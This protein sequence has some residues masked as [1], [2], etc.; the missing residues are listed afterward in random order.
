MQNQNQQQNLQNST[1]MPPQQNEGG[2]SLFDT[3]EALGTVTGTLEHYL[4]YEQHI[5]DQ[6]LTT[7]LQ[8]H[9]TFISQLYNTLVETLK[10]GQDPSVPTQTYNMSLNNDVVYGMQPSAPKT[11]SQSVNEINDECVSSFMLGGLKSIATAFTT[12]ALEATNPVL[13]RVFSDSIPNVIEMAYEVFLYQNK[14]QYY[15]VPQLK[16]QDMQALLN[17]YAPIPGTMPH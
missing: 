14:H 1:Q 9:R 12:T 10:S 8:S 5:Q 4:L 7:I 16:E 17:S 3:H 13:R 6:E 15:Q 11:P 2:H